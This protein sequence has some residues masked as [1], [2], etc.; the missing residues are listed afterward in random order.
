MGS[1]GFSDFSD[2]PD[3]PEP[4]R[5]I[6]RK[7]GRHPTTLPDDDA[8]I[9]NGWLS[10]TGNVDADGMATGYN[11]YDPAPAGYDQSD[12]QVAQV[13]IETAQGDRIPAYIAS[14]HEAQLIEAAPNQ[15]SAVPAIEAPYNPQA[16]IHV[17]MSSA[18]QLNLPSTANGNLLLAGTSFQAI[19]TTILRPT[20]LAH[21]L[22]LTRH[23]N[24]AIAI[25]AS[26]VRGTPR[27]TM[28]FLDLALESRMKIYRYCFV[29]GGVISF[30]QPGS[31]PR[32]ASFLA[33]C[34]QICQEGRRVLYSENAFHLERSKARR[35]EYYE[36][37]WSEIGFQDIYRFLN[38]IGPHNVSLLRYVCIELADSV[39]PAARL[40]EATS[41]QISR[42]YVNDPVLYT[43]MKNLLGPYAHL[44]KLTIRLMGRREMRPATDQLFLDALSSVK[45]E[46]V[47]F[48][49]TWRGAALAAQ[50]NLR[51]QM[52]VIRNYV[53]HIDDT[54]RN[55]PR[56]GLYLARRPAP[57]VNNDHYR[58]EWIDEVGEVHSG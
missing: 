51:N 44:R 34:K 58:S 53:D 12:P 21:N 31:F 54:E 42:R 9:R 7:H 45:T 22:M 24:D 5:H 25:Q 38:N 36:A 40:S 20:Q 14:K 47:E 33:T 55:H 48:Y 3:S 8:A 11:P 32:S 39:L 4:Q 50:V 6:F 46:Q 35:G 16:P 57:P 43:V 30:T 1:S 37:Q 23:Q 41:E 52:I 28:S 15:A 13:Y 18:R 29:S 56:Y 49:G 2:N 26:R 27:M 17:P 10:P 19:D